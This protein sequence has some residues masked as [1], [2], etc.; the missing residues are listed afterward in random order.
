MNNEIRFLSE[1]EKSSVRDLWERTFKEDGKGF[2]D[3][4]FDVYKDMTEV[5]GMVNVDDEVS[6][7]VLLCMLHMNPYQVMWQGQ[8]YDTSYVV[9]VATDENHRRKGYMRDILKW[10]LRNRYEAGEVFSLLMPIDSR[11]YD[12]FGY[13]FVQDVMIYKFYYKN[14]GRPIREVPCKELK[15]REAIEMLAPYNHYKRQFNLSHN[16]GMRACDMLVAEANSEGG[17]VVAVP[18]GYV[19]YYPS[20]SI[21]VREC[22][23]TSSEGLYNILD[24]IGSI[25]GDKKIEW[26]MPLENPLGHLIPH[27]TNHERVRK[28]F[29]MVRINR[30]HEM[31][32]DM[33]G[34][35]GDLV[36][37]VSDGQLFE[38][39]STYKLSG[40]SVTKTDVDPD[41]TIDV[42]SLAQWL[43]GYESLETLAFVR[44]TVTIH[45][46]V[47]YY[48]ELPVLNYFNE[49]V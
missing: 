35:L 39:N 42:E 20:E 1:F 30:V 23:Y 47:I 40:G 10:T 4:Y 21:F 31:L 32:E 17:K 7:N 38:N 11:Y 33:A 13:G 46:D 6:P 34:V 44:T 29:M 5:V 15:P 16:R 9:G 24:Y 41:L 49:F 26:Q 12:Q 2:V 22:V 25:A 28:P 45:R 19:V 43:F 18:E 37:K 36:I 48:P 8:L 14:L 3:H 27:M